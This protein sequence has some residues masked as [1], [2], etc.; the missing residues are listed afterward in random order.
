MESQHLGCFQN[1][2]ILGIV[3]CLKP[4]YHG[5][6]SPL[7]IRMASLCKSP[8]CFALDSLTHRSSDRP[9]WVLPNL[10][11][12]MASKKSRRNWQRQIFSDMSSDFMDHGNHSK[13]CKP[14]AN[15]TL[16][17]SDM[18]LSGI[19][20]SCR[21]PIRRHVKGNQPSAHI[22]TTT[23]VAKRNPRSTSKLRLLGFEKLGPL[24]CFGKRGHQC[25]MRPTIRRLILAA[26]QGF[27]QA[28]P[29]QGSPNPRRLWELLYSIRDSWL[30]AGCVVNVALLVT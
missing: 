9:C 27:N 20:K 18:M 25:S 23:R 28:A 24:F 11:S 7:R 10:G 19:F 12:A 29:V 13:T 6:E 22:A 14:H 4:R 5:H 17:C 26:Q 21:P 15:T 30:K 3:S 8:R 2:E 1:K 16:T